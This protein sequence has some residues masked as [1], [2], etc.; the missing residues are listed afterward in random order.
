MNKYLFIILIC[1][2]SCKTPEILEEVQKP[3]PEIV[4]QPGV[5]YVTPPPEDDRL[6]TEETLRLLIAEFFSTV[7]TIIAMFQIEQSTQ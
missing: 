6:W 2:A 5:I 7:S 3:T 1:L 4:E